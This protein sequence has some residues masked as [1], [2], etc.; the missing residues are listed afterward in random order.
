[1][2]EGFTQQRCPKCGGNIYIGRDLY[3]GW[4]EKCLQCSRTWYLESVVEVRDKVNKCSAREQMHTV[5]ASQS[6]S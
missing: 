1:M 3:A 4:F 5:S 6:N 2:R